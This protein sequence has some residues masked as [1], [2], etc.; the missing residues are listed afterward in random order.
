MRA[1]GYEFGEYFARY[2]AFEI[3]RLE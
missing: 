2:V 1:T 3:N